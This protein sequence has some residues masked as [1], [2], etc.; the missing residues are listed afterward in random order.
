MGL[1]QPQGTLCHPGTLCQPQ[2]PCATLANP[3][4]PWGTLSH[5]GDSLT[6]QDP[7][8]ASEPCA[9]LGTLRQRLP[10]TEA[11]GGGFASLPGYHGEM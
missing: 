1:C 9:T 6:S 8:P 11:R 7:V 3:V 5:P 10:G 2:G 4:P